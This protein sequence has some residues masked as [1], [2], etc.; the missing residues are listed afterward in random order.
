MSYNKVLLYLSAMTDMHAIVWHTAVTRT[1]KS[2][3]MLSYKNGK[4]NEMKKKK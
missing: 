3:T 1:L 4:M 2:H